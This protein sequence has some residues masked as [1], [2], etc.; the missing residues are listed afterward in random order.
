M[1]PL[2]GLKLLFSK[3]YRRYAAIPIAINMSVFLGLYT[4]GL[5][6]FW[7]TF[8]G[9]TIQLPYGFGWLESALT[10]LGPL[11]FWLG[12]IGV[13]LAML[14]ALGNISS[15]I[16][17]VIASPFNSLLAEKILERN[18]VIHTSAPFGAMM[19]EAI[20][21]ETGK[22]W[23]LLPKLILTYFIFA[24][25]Y[26]IP[27]INMLGAALLFLFSTWMLS[28]EYIDYAAETQGW[29]L[30]QYKT[31]IKRNKKITLSFGASSM[32]LSSI[33]LLNLLSVPASVAGSA[34][35]WIDLKPTATQT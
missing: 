11:F 9:A 25:L 31:W 17:S 10:W 18:G 26:F 19:K 22:L 4:L 20:L 15:I 30:S 12:F 28:F 1:Y 3:G 16:A 29:P 14:L 32:L 33:P 34:L 24:L 8:S 7:M 5:R 13:G 27:I 2:K 35:L 23:H 6:W 21:R